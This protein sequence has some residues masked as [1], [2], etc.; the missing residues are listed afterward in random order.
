MQHRLKRSVALPCRAEE[1]FAWHEMP[2]VLERLTPPWVHYDNLKREGGISVGATTSMRLKVGPLSLG[3]RSEHTRYEPGRCFAD[4]MVKGPFSRF[5]HTHTFENI[6][7]GCRLTD[8]LVYSLPMAPA[9]NLVAKYWVRRDLERMFRYR[10]LI[11][12]R[13][14]A[15]YTA[16]AKTDKPVVAISGASGVIGSALVPFLL[17]QGYGVKTLVRRKPKVASEIFWDPEAGVMDAEGLSGCDVVIHLAGENIGDG[18]WTPEKRERI[19]A[20]REKGTT[21]L[22]R[23]ASSLENGPKLFLSA[24]AVGFY[25]DCQCGAVSEKSCHGDAFISKVCHLWERAAVENWTRKEGRLVNLRIG[26]VLTP[27]G[28]ALARLLPVFKAGLGGTIGSG[29]QYMSWISMEDVLSAM[30]HIMETPELS[31]PVNLTAPTPETN[32]GFTK[33]LARTVNRYALTHL[34]SPLVTAA[35][36]AMGREVLLEGVKALPEAL[37]DSGYTF[38]HPTLDSALSEVIL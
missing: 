33:T 25:G 32:R 29:K 8:E 27:A 7:E 38:I 37:L 31:G 17:S 21:L 28:G 16:S 15:R 3:W 10:H 6:G 9:S 1:A 36:G 5:E 23:T 2:G 24:S 30:V 13:D 18:R 14:L 34:P 26:V 11:T 12:A 35:F 22:T 20:S 4:R 19:I